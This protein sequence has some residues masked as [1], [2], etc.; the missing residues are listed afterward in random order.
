[1]QYTTVLL[2]LALQTYDW[3][4][5]TNYVF[6]I[7]LPGAGRIETINHHFRLH[8]GLKFCCT[9]PNWIESYNHDQP[10]LR[11]SLILG[12]AWQILDV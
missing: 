9:H 10:M 11:Y 2:Y 12:I 5:E 1:M 7:E 8:F 4:E 3:K 6:L